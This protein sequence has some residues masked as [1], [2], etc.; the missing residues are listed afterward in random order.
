MSI[1]AQKRLAKLSRK[2]PADKFIEVLDFAEFLLAR[3]AAPANG[4]AKARKALRKY[5]GG[6]RHGTLAFAIDDELYGRP[7]R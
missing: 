6:V 3:S 4:A 1:V 2:L 5:I 7:V